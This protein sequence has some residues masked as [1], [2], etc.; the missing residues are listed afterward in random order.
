MDYP[1]V[2]T[3]FS[4]QGEGMHAGHLVNFVRL[5]GCPINCDFCDTDKREKE[6]QNE[7]AIAR[8]MTK[9]FPVVITGGEPCIHDLRPLTKALSDSI[10][11]V[12]LETS[13]AYPLT[14]QF[15]HVA[16]SPKKAAHFRIDVARN[17]HEVKWLVPEWTLEEI[18]VLIPFFPSWTRHSIQPINDFLGI[19]TLNVKGAM[20]VA[21]TLKLPL[22]IQ[23]HKILK[24][25]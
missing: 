1:I 4:V 15:G 3:F 9:G 21:E 24:V 19:N 7:F 2:E 25:R 13:G 23:L 10:F 20:I 18:V 6:S 16:V 14:G 5:A 8:R 17:T 22:S 12:W 11:P